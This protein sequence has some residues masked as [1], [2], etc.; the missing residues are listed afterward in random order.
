MTIAEFLARPLPEAPGLI[1]AERTVRQLLADRMGCQMGSLDAFPE[2]A[3]PADVLTRLE[4][5]LTQ[6]AEG[7]PPA[8]VFG[9]VP[10]LDWDFKIDAR[11]LIPRPETEALCYFVTRRYAGKKPPCRVL[12]LCCGS[13]VLGLSLALTFPESSVVLTDLCPNALA[14]CEENAALHGLRNRVQ[15]CE[16]DLWHA[17]NE[18]DRFDLIVANPPYVAADDR[19]EQSVRLWEP[20]VALY[21]ERGGTAHIEGI[22][23]R[24]D[25]FLAPNGFAAFE[26]GHYHA[27]TFVP[28]PGGLTGAFSWEADPFGVP[29]YLIYDAPDL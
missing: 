11:A 4:T 14:L 23:K 17:V 12:D 16:G 27:E 21:S 2:R 25:H 3:I 9:H 15:L 10:F 19:V 28:Q 26:L 20:P 13:G 7:H 24:L 1:H 5:D 8:H 22:L 18:E 29:R 6:L